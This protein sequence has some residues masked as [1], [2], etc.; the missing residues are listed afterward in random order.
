MRSEDS[1]ES[2]L[3]HVQCKVRGLAHLLTLALL[4]PPLG[5][6]GREVRRGQRLL[7][8]PGPRVG[9]T[10]KGRP[11][12]PATA[13]HPIGD[14]GKDGGREDQERGQPRSVVGALHSAGTS[15]GSWSSR[16][17]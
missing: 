6:G 8:T 17:P 10:W 11:T 9:L 16:A 2:R 3:K 5:A 4:V 13:S 14:C 15:R 1:V 7:P 12:S